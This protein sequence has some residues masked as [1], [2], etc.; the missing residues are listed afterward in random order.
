ML[1]C[2]DNVMTKQKATALIQFRVTAKEKREY[3]ER[4]AA[5]GWTLSQ[6]IRFKLRAR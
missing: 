2:H 4:A 1:L 3:K 6:F 5:C